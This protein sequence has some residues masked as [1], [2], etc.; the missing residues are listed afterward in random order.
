MQLHYAETLIEIPHSIDNDPFLRK[1]G[2][3]SQGFIKTVIRHSFLTE[4]GTLCP[5]I[6]LRISKIE[7]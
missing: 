1:Q 5:S 7:F 2:L 3:K 6:F 4:N